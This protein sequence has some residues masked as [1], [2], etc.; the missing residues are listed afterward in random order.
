MLLAA[1]E[2]G[3]RGGGRGLLEQLPLGQLDQG[4]ERVTHADV[5]IAPG[6]EG[7]L[8]MRLLFRVKESHQGLVE[9]NHRHPPRNE[10]FDVGLVSVHR[11]IG[12]TGLQGNVLERRLVLFTEC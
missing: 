12:Q 11:V 6:L 4:V 1:G 10:L 2:D 7:F 5:V 8:R 9:G 3:G